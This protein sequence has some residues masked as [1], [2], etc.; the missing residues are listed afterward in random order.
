VVEVDAEYIKG[1]LNHPDLL[2]NATLNRW[3]AI[4]KLSDFELKHVP[5]DKHKAPDG[6]SRRPPTSEE[7]AEAEADDVEGWIDETLE[8]FAL[9]E[10][11]P[12][13]PDNR[14]STIPAT[15]KSNEEW[16]EL[17]EIKKFLMTLQF[18]QEN[19]PEKVRKLT[20]KLEATRF[21]VEEGR[22]YKRN[23]AGNHQRV[24]G[25]KKRLEILHQIHDELGHKGFFPC[26]TRLYTRFWWPNATEDL[27]WY[28]KTCQEC[29]ERNIM[30]INIP[31]TVPEPA[32][33]FGQIHVDT[34]FMPKA[35]GFRYIV[36]AV[37]SLSGWPEAKALA[38]EKGKTIGDFLF[39]QILCR[40]GAVRKI[41]TDN[42]KPFIKA[43]EYISE[44]YGIRHIRISP[45]NSQA[46]GIVEC[47]HFGL[48][49]SLVKLCGNRLNDWPL[50]LNLALWAQRVTTKKGLGYSPYYMAYGLE[51]TFPFDIEEATYLAP[52]LDRTVSTEELVALR[53]RQLEKREDDLQAMKEAIW[54]RRRE[55]A[56]EFSKRN[57]HTIRGYHF[58]PGRLVLVRNSGDEGGLR[59]KYK[60]R[61]L[62]PYVV[63][64]RNEGGAYILA[65]MDGTVS[66]LCFAAKRL[67]PYHLRSRIKLPNANE[68][69]ENSNN[70]A[71]EGAE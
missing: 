26:R 43:L 46:Q 47:A 18:S 11:I 33:L 27:K 2:P 69:I 56:G 23:P 63:V 8:T 7:K 39:N 28:L 17:R 12:E 32:Q 62:G 14:D 70:R 65:E 31:P 20:Q 9:K 67:I 36:H 59:N 68:A 37:C 21:F 15:A 19:D 71:K 38:Y 55:L 4:I 52:S 40:Y 50:K 45:Y 35:R 13:S 64:Y 44:K 25:K 1:M 51:P 54:K 22:L 30:K 66:N 57:E 41:V 5:A 58:E 60:P 16:G 3:I 10:G 61:Y 34:M 6:L 42:G 48:R 29:Q 53:A 24:I 49:E